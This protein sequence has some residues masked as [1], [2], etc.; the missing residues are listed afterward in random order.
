[1]IGMKQQMAEKNMSLQQKKMGGQDK[2]EGLLK[3]TNTGIDE[4]FIAS[5]ETL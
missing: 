1:M 5:N 3:K 4:K 2:F